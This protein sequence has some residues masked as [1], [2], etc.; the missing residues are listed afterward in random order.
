M[1]IRIDR[2]PPHRFRTPHPLH[3]IAA[4]CCMP[5]ST[6]ALARNYPSNSIAGLATTPPRLSCGILLHGWYPSSLATKLLRQSAACLVS[7]SS[8]HKISA[9]FCCIL[10][11]AAFL[12]HRREAVALEKPA[13]FCCMVGSMASPRK[14]KVGATQ[15]PGGFPRRER[16]RQPQGA[17]TIACR[18][19]AESGTS[20]APSHGA[21]ARPHAIPCANSASNTRRQPRQGV[22][23]RGFEVAS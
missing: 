2:S 13:A 9:V 5:T 21:E 14:Q 19:G 1:T 23:V 10:A 18:A 11:S 15:P 7:V 8:G 12:P 3:F 22:S 6:P 4:F 17:A 20:L 16:R